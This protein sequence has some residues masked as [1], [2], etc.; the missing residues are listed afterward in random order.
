MR[1]FLHC[2]NMNVGTTAANYYLAVCYD[3]TRCQRL[4][5]MGLD[6]LRKAVLVLR[7]ADWIFV[8]KLVRGSP[9]LEPCPNENAMVTPSSP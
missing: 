4:V 3:A 6:F 8:P 7:L 9:S 2:V 1:R 5:K